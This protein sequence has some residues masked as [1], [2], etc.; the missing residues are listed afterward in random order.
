MINLYQPNQTTYQQAKTLLKHDELVVFP[1]ETIYGLWANALSDIAAKKIF[2]VKGR[3]SD[4]PLIVHLWDKQ[5]I[6]EY[7]EIENEV[8][9]TV[10][11][12][13]MPW[14]I[15]LLLKK[16]SLISNIV[17]PVEY[18]GIRLPS[19]QIAQQFL[20]TVNLPI[21]APSANISGKPS[22][23]NAQ[24]VYD[25]IGDNI[26]M[27]I[28]GGESEAGIESSVVRV[29]EEDGKYTI[30]ILRP[31]F[32]TKEDLEACFEGTVEV[33]YSQKNPELA[34]G[35]RYKHYSI[36]G[37]VKIISSADEIII[38]SEKS[39]WVLVTKEFF[40][41]HQEELEKIED[42]IF[43]KIWGSY[44]N[45]ATCAHSLFEFYHFFDMEG[46]DILYVEQLP[47]VGIGYSIMNR[48]KRSAEIS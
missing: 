2:E 32:V 43:L 16:K 45:L 23:T 40:Q 21:A 29:L 35:M 6:S 20:R 25:N 3:P 31:G 1:T 13:L 22:P 9:Q 11:D 34:P 38:P 18:V 44:G 48:V 47:E 17:C 42:Q 41:D 26:P 8:Q 4:N 27:I 12:K 28:D 39:V 46:V 7:A 5:Q 10:I 14:P 36:D 19:N 37:E 24:M 30:L 33:E 15:T